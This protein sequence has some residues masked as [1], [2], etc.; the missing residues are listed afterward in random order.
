ML[1]MQHQFELEKNQIAHDKKMNEIKAQY[2]NE[3]DQINKKNE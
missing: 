2:R 1:R 3:L